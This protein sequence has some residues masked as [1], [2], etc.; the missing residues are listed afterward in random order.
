MSSVR[1]DW[2]LAELEDDGDDPFDT[3]ILSAGLDVDLD[4]PEAGL[5]EAIRRTLHI[6]SRLYNQGIEC[7]LKE[8]GQDCLT[9]PEFTAR[10]D[11]QRAPL[12]LIG[13]DQK[14]IERADV[15]RRL[16]LKELAGFAEE[17]SE[18]GHLPE[19]YAELLTARGL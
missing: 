6:E 3:V 8:Q 16:P 17:L 13:R 1:A 5:Y 2:R 12:C 7:T 14:V 18:I 10:P 19:E 15:V 4:G 11:Q 9:C